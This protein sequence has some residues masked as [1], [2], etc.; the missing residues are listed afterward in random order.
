MD[1]LYRSGGIKGSEIGKLLE[2]DYSTVSQGRKRLRDML[3]KDRILKQIVN[4]I[5]GKLSR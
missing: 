4:R 2:V 1:L 5:E 3:K